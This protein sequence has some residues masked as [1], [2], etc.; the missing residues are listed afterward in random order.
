MSALKIAAFMRHG[1]GNAMQARQFAADDYRLKIE[2]NIDA[3]ESAV[4]FGECRSVIGVSNNASD[5]FIAP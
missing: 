5:S 4:S 3:R 2:F 1:R